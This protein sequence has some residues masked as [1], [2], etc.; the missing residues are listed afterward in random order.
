MP[1]RPKTELW[2]HRPVHGSLQGRYCW[3][4]ARCSS[5]T[6][7]QSFNVL[8]NM[9]PVHRQVHWQQVRLA[10]FLAQPCSLNSAGVRA[11]SVVQHSRA[12]AFRHV[13]LPGTL[14]HLSFSP[15]LTAVVCVQ[16]RWYITAGLNPLFDTFDCQEHFFG[17]PEEGAQ[18]HLNLLQDVFRSRA[19]WLLDCGW[20]LEQSWWRDSASM[21][22]SQ[23]G[24]AT[25][26]LPLRCCHHTPLL[27]LTAIALD[28]ADLRATCC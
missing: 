21:H 22:G 19:C 13:R 11:G 3:S 7:A 25:L 9:P 28:Q 2:R 17:V 27:N 23:E 15:V 24:L 10:R 20:V 1:G 18:P 5:L 26:S 8:L 12:P 16:G 14:F 4:W 6:S